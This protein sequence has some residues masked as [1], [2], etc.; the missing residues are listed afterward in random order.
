ME[1][2]MYYC[3]DCWAE[4]GPD[5]VTCPGCGYRMADFDSL[6]FESKLILALKHPIRV[7][8]MLA[9]QLLGERRYRG[10]VPAFEPILREE[11]DPYVLGEIARASARIGDDEGRAIVSRLRSHPSAVVRSMAERSWDALTEA[12]S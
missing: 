6:P 9:I 10:A 5:V 4:V 3:P 7:N 8:R 1:S 2:L 11:T 12:S